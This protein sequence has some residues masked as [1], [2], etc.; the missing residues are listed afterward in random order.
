VVRI[1]GD[2]TGRWAKK[3]PGVHVSEVDGGAVRLAVDE[4]ADS[5]LILDAAR[6]AGR[7]TEFHFERRRLSEVFREALA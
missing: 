7:V 1:E 4:D 2:R 6:A 3:L 5:E